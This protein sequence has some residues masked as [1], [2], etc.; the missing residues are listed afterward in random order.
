[1]SHDNL[2]D[3]FARLRDEW[4]IGSIVENVMAKIETS[5]GAIRRPRARGNR[6]AL[7]V[8]ASVL[9]AAAAVASF[10]IVSQPTTLLAA[11]QN[12]LARARSAHLVITVWNTKE[13]PIQ[14]NVWYLRDKGLRAESPEE[15]LIDDGHLQLSWPLRGLASERFV[16]RQPSPGYFTSEITKLFALPDIPVEWARSRAPELDRAVGGQQC[17]G[18]IVMQPNLKRDTLVMQPN[19]KRDTPAER[20]PTPAVTIRG[21]VLADRDMRVHEIMIQERQNDASWK[22]VRKIELELEVAVPEERVAARLPEDLRVID[23]DKVFEQC[24]PLD[25]ALFRTE[26]GGLNFAVHDMRP[27]VDRDGFYVVSSVRGTPEFLKKYPPRRRPINAEVVALDVASQQFAS[28][29]LSAKYDR[30]GMATAAREG[31]EYVWWMIIPRKFFK[32]KD[33]KR[34]YEPESNVSFNQ[35]EPMRLDD[36]PGK[37]RV[38]LSAYYW[39]EHH[40]DARGVQQTVEKWVEVPI[41][42]DRAPSTIE[43][44][45]AR[46]RRDLLLMRHGG[47]YA[48]LGVAADAKG[49]SQNLKPM[50]SFEP[51][52]ITDAGYA[53]A[54]RRGFEDLRRVDEIVDAGPGNIVAPR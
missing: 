35:Y 46:V 29:N 38:K 16:L 1:M 42:A 34:V 22:N 44:V 47:T 23:R 30:V 49:D 41:P 21:L 43:D 52:Q 11:V 26:I 36:L 33:G 6:L 37:A 12:E 8:A 27:L 45:A 28:G 3:R 13:E 2:E 32:L 48:L 4:P 24:Y 19:L 39:D 53:A 50:S 18:Y 31:V 20:Q 14:S 5:A 51:D 7:A 15:V 9:L 10:M 17:S 25:R 40:R 54:V